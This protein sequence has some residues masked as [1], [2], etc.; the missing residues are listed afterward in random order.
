MPTEQNVLCQPVI[1]IVMCKDLVLYL[2]FP[3]QAGG[4]V[5]LRW[6]AA[7]LVRS[8]LA[9]TSLEGALCPPLG[10]CSPL[11]SGRLCRST[12]FGT[13]M[14]FNA[15]QYNEASVTKILEHKLDRKD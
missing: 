6:F 5:H 4:A 1:I 14:F 2:S 8:G 9:V 3:G 13:P 11:L 7:C 15:L 12:A 10:P